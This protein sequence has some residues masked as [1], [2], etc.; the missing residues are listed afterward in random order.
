MI[1][2][3]TG[4]SGQDGS[5]LSELLLSLG[6][7]VHACIRH[8]SVIT[9]PRIE[10]LKNNSNFF[11][12]DLDLTD[13][14]SILEVVSKVS[15]NEIYNLGAQ[16]HVKVSYSTPEFTTNTNALGTLRMLEG[17]KKL[18]IESKIKFYQASTSELFGSANA[19]T[20]NEL[21]PFSPRSPYGISKLYAYWMVVHHRDAYG[22]FASNGIL[23]NHESPRR[24]QNFVSRKISVGVSRIIRG[25][26]KFISLGALDVRRDWGHAKDYV[27]AIHS[28]LNHSKPEDFVIATGQSHSVREFVESAFKVVDI[29]IKWSGIGVDEIGIDAN[30]GKTLIKVDPKFFR[31]GIETSLCGDASKA[32]R[33]L[34]W[35]H[36]ISFEDLV[37]EMVLHDLDEKN[38]TSKY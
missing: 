33:A 34:G 25:E 12:H 6:Y 4:A 22:M 5:Y 23:F 20:Q 17:I 37:K 9:T 27:K 29:D 21:T 3:I 38:N 28:I 15:P 36:E 18:G 26:S 7:Q 35:R 30:T 14:Y 24:P 10:H 31:A 11:V 2:L 32:K 1:A 8:S 19:S 16:S 13:S